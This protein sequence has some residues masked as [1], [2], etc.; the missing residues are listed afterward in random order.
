[1]YLK[2][3][4]EMIGVE[5]AGKTKSFIIAQEGMH[6]LQVPSL[7]SFLGLGLQYLKNKKIK[8]PKSEVLVRLVSPSVRAPTTN[9]HMLVVYTTDIYLSQF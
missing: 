4:E 1:M 5:G 6:E 3:R 9:Y 2:E 7:N 8:T